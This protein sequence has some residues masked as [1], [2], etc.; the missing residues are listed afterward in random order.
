MANTEMDHRADDAA[1][2]QPYIDDVK[3]VL[4]G[5]KT[6]AAACT[7]M[8]PKFPREQ[9][10]NYTF[11]VS[12]AKLTNVFEDI[13]ETLAAKPFSHECTLSDYDKQPA[14]IQALVEDIDGKGNHFHV[15][16]ADT[17]F[18]GLAYV[19]DWILVDYSV[20]EVLRTRADEKA[21]GARPYW[22]H[23]RQSNVLEVRSSVVNGRERIDYFRMLE[24]PEKQVCVYERD[25]PTGRVTWS[26]WIKL[27]DGT[28][29][30][31]RAAAGAGQEGA[32]EMGE[33]TIGV[34][35]V[36]PFATGRRYGDR[37]AWHPPFRGALELQIQLYRAESSFAHTK[38]LAAFP[39]LAGNGIQPVMQGDQ[40]KDVPVGPGAILYAPPNADGSHGTWDWLQTDS[41]LLSFLSKDIETLK[42]DLREL[43]RQPL[44]AQSGNLTRITTQFAAQKGNTALQSWALTMKDALEQAWVLTF[45]WLAASPADAPSVQIY[46]DFAIDA[47][48]ELAINALIEMWRGSPDRGP[49][50]S[51]ESLR[52]QMRARSVLSAEYEEEEEL[53]RLLKEAAPGLEEVDEEDAADQ[54]PTAPDRTG[55]QEDEDQV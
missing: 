28:W 35:P 53:R 5:E 3:A 54:D 14:D 50:L 52:R 37:W 22:T 18:N 25:M 1:E 44:T 23:V 10:V 51:A 36:V 47:E 33:I 42:Q 39:M 30:V 34:I 48:S 45:M 49:A 43:G 15:F 17:F 32:P 8:L 19:V 29:E 31:K 46:T 16:A 55:Q 6:M 40:P 26:R 9:I 24:I 13:I 41:A 21:A 4:G 27:D 7:R 12:S 38:T 11:R 2:L 20:T